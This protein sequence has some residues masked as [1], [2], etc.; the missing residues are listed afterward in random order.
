[1][2]NE[3]F[4]TYARTWA[5]IMAIER[6]NSN[7]N[8]TTQNIMGDNDAY[9]IEY[10]GALGEIITANY[11]T[12]VGATFP[13]ELNP[14]TTGADFIIDGKRIDVKTSTFETLLVYEDAVNNY[15]IYIAVLY[16]EDDDWGKVRGW[17]TKE[18]LRMSEPK[19]AKS[20]D[21]MNHWMI[22]DKLN[23]MYGLQL[24]I[25]INRQDVSD[26]E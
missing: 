17:T 11:V 12:T 10:K 16:N 13:W 25:D 20:G 14:S 22:Y 4:R 1:M 23:D 9:S 26:N 19:K 18:L 15:D 3:E 2:E 6:V 24:F 8:F 5:D 21:R 7:S